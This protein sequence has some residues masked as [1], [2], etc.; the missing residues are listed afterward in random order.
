M[1]SAILLLFWHDSAA[2][3]HPGK[4]TACVEQLEHNYFQIQIP[5]RSGQL[6]S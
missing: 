4:K 2:I 6:A 1:E 3:L 5:Y